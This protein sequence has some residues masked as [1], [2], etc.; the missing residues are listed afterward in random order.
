[1]RAATEYVIDRGYRRLFFVC[2]PINGDK[3][4][5][6]YVH[7][8]RLEGFDQAV[9]RAGD[10]E[11]EYMLDWDYLDSVKSISITR[12]TAFICT[13][14]EIAL[15]IMMCLKEKKLYPGKDYGLHG[16]DDIDTLKYISP[17]LSSVN[18]NVEMV[19]CE[20]TKLLVSMIEDEAGISDDARVIVPFS[21]VKGQ[22]V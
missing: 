9:K 3:N 15:E 2:P 13:S 10:T 11:V 8:K 4:G 19:A 21:L 5:N 12:D 6:L 18:N 7:K 17:R 16:F 1:M 22:T 20:A 14:D